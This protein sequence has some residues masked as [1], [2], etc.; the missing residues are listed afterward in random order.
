METPSALPSTL[1]ERLRSAATA[2]TFGA[3]WK[4]ANHLLAGHPVV[5]SFV[6]TKENYADVGILTDVFVL[7]CEGNEENQQGQ[8]FVVPLRVP[9]QLGFLIGPVPSLPNGESARLVLNIYAPD[10]EVLAYWVATSDREREEL[11]SFGSAVS[12]A[13]SRSGL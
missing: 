8:V 6:H 12:Q 2:Q 7:G 13:V 9:H 11:L 3:Y 4:I 1:T 10:N 5:A